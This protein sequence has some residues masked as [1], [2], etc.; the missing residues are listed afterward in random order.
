MRTLLTLFLAA[1]LAA[2]AAPTTPLATAPQPA[3]IVA[4]GTLASVG[5]CEYRIASEATALAVALHR[6]ARALDA[7]RIDLVAARQAHAL[8]EQAR[9]HL[10]RACA[11]PAD[12]IRERAEA[13]QAREIRAR[14]T[15]LIGG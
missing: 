1:L 15:T 6:A 10:R 9:E 14:I 13:A 11:P 8:G 2:C 4:F 5:T 12:E 3:R 7:G